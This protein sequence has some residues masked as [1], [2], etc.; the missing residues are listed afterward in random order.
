[1]E[2]S[3]PFFVNLSPFSSD[4]QSSFKSLTSGGPTKTTPTIV[5]N[6]KR[7]DN[8]KENA[9]SKSSPQTSN[10][11]EATIAKV[12]DDNSKVQ[13]TN[14]PDNKETSVLDS[15]DDTPREE[16]SQQSSISPDMESEDGMDYVSD[17][18]DQMDDFISTLTTVE[19][20]LIDI[21]NSPTKI[22]DS[23]EPKE[24]VTITT[25]D[26]TPA[27]NDSV[28]ELNEGS[29]HTEPN[30]LLDSSQD[31]SSMGS[32]LTNEDVTETSLSKEMQGDS[33]GIGK[34]ANDN[35]SSCMEQ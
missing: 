28:T 19:T 7:N 4:V 16:N 34:L 10:V 30:P 15:K 11:N 35:N 23:N 26:V 12:N 3:K 20:E 29:L 31:T 9:K 22:F 2:S 24:F 25:S 32:S 8:H 33:G 5:V 27:N 6:L 21:G 1:M 17:I 14:E 13:S 18:I